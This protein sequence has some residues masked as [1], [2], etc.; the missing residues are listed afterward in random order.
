MSVKTVKFSATHRVDSSIIQDGIR[1][2]LDPIFFDYSEGDQF[3][4]YEFA[5]H[6]RKTNGKGATSQVTKVTGVSVNQVV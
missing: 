4:P 6:V 3:S 1:V 5:A 2:H